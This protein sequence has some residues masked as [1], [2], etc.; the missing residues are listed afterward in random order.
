MKF[1]IKL[2]KNR[3]EINEM[4]SMVYSEDALNPAMVYKLVKRFQ[5]GS[6]GIVDDARSSHLSFSHSEENV[7]HVCMFMFVSI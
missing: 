2:G 7:D 5:E 1:L 4:L 3:T 6:E